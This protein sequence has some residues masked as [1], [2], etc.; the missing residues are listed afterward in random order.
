MTGER[1]WLILADDRTGAADAAIAFA[2]RGLGTEVAWGDAACACRRGMPP[3]VLSLDLASRRLPAAAAA[4]RH[5]EAL[6]SIAALSAGRAW[7]V[8]KKIDSTLRGQPAAEI[9][10]TLAASGTAQRPAIGILTPS[11]PATGRVTTGGRVHVNGRP[12]ETTEIWREAAYPAADLAAILSSAG[13]SSVLLPLTVIRAGAGPVLQ[14]L[15]ALPSGHV[16]ICD[17]ETEA[18]LATIAAAGLAPGPSVVFIGSAGLAH[19]IANHLPSRPSV[20]PDVPPDA[21]GILVVVGSRAEASRRAARSLAA[22]PGVRTFP[23]TPR[24]LIDGAAA[25]RSA[26]TASVTAGLRAGAAVLV[27]IAVGP[28][29]AAVSDAAGPSLATALAGLLAPAA[30]EMAGLVATGGETAAALLDGLG[31]R[32]LRLLDEIEPGV[33]LGLM[34]GGPGRPVAT[35]AGGFGDAG[36]LLRIVRHLDSFRQEKGVS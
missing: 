35:K 15:A 20:P 25:E 28:G 33:A 12:L 13:L 5:R 6:R 14:A 17:A 8:F 26:F 32:G 24:L 18:D 21:G 7:T 34:I 11:F 3:D 16:A 4:A 23:A 10:A 22:V 29:D 27:E 30:P 31:V 1:R 9:A 19:A 36:S 2:R